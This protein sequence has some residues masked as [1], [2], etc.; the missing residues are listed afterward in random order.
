MQR[1]MAEKHNVIMDGRHRHRGKARLR[2]GKDFLNTPGGG[3]KRRTTSWIGMDRRWTTNKNPLAIFS[4]GTIRH[5]PEI[6]PWKMARDSVKLTL[7]LDIDGVIAAM[8]EIIAR[9]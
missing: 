6:A 7:E 5:P 1:E 2:H 3:Q 4:S 8:K 9:R